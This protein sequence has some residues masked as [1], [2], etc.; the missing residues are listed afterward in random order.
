MLGRTVGALAALSLGANAILLPP[1]ISKISDSRTGAL[2]LALDPKSQAV[3]VHCSGCV[4]PSPQQESA[5]EKGDDDIFWIQGGSKDVL[6]NFTIDDNEKDLLLDGVKVYPVDGGFAFDEPTVGQVQSS[7]S[8]ASI[9]SNPEQITPLHV[10]SAGM[11]VHEETISSANDR[12][13][14]INY[15]IGELESQPMAVDGVNLKLLKGAD[16]SLMII[17]VDAVPSD[18]VFDGTPLSGRPSKECGMLPAALCKWKSVV[19]DKISDFKPSMPHALGGCG[20]RKDPH[21]L[22]G[23]IKPHFE[24]HPDFETRPDRHHPHGPGGHPRPHHGPHGHHGPHR[25]H[26][27][28]HHFLPAFVHAFVAVLI[29]VMAGITMG[30]FVSLIGMLVGRLISFVWIRFGRGGQRGYASVAQTEQDT[31]NAEKGIVLLENDVD[32]ESLP[33]YEDAPAYDEKDRE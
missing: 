8:L 16:G 20:G 30:M 13:V 29:P 22:P 17:S 23:H 1:G 18:H 14:V 25:G 15:Q 4:F 21:R 27:R 2:G 10:S 12:L 7:A 9:K 28:H 33:K 26:H 6:F 31:E 5:L 11:R 24:M 19:E 32:E 3:K